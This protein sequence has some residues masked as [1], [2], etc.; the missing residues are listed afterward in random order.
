[1]YEYI[2]RNKTINPF[3]NNA[4][5]YWMA[6]KKDHYGKRVGANLINAAEI[7]CRAHGCIEHGF[8]LWAAKIKDTGELIGYVGL[9]IPSFEAHFTPC[10]EIG[11]RLASILCYAF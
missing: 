5:V 9:S 4:N 11:W 10:V 8:G 7:Y 1:L 6:V 3:S 2:F